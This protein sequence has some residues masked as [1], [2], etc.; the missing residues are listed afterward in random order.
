MVVVDLLEQN[1]LMLVGTGLVQKVVH[2]LHRVVVVILLHN[3][4]EAFSHYVD[5]GLGDSEVLLDDILV[6][7]PDPGVKRENGLDAVV[8]LSNGKSS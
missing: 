1:E 3:G 2:A 5:R 8:L 7:A 6:S 4:S